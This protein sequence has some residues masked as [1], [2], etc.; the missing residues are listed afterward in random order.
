MCVCVWRFISIHM[1]Y[2]HAKPILHDNGG[3]PS[4]WI[5]DLVSSWETLARKK[6]PGLCWPLH[7][8]IETRLLDHHT[9]GVAP[10]IITWGKLSVLQWGHFRA[11]WLFWSQAFAHLQASRHPYGDRVT[12]P[13]HNIQG[14]ACKNKWMQF[15]EGRRSKKL[16]TTYNV[17]LQRRRQTFIHHI[18][19]TPRCLRSWE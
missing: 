4:C 6:A 3:T 15:L 19:N 13:E 12:T 2:L 17:C 9:D 18:S 14:M 5:H 7:C 1:D 8:L 10:W 16:W 11:L